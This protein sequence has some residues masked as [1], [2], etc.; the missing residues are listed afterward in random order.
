VITAVFYSTEKFGFDSRYVLY[1]SCL[2]YCLNSLL[3]PSI[4][5]NY[6]A[7]LFCTIAQLLTLN[8]VC[9]VML[10]VQNSCS[11]ELVICIVCMYV[12]KF[13]SAQLFTA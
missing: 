1:I 12:S 11:F 7:I 4:K 5:L 8:S 6:I 3:I 13:M 9:S 2:L 10:Y